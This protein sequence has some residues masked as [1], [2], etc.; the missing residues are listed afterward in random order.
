MLDLLASN[1]AS[2]LVFTSKKRGVLV[3]DSAA[4]HYHRTTWL[5]VLPSVPCF[6]FCMFHIFQIGQRRGVL[7][8]SMFFRKESSYSWMDGLGMV[9]VYWEPTKDVGEHSVWV[10]FQPGQGLNV[11]LKKTMHK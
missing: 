5:Y 2:D 6:A 3:D 7:R 9:K 8:V 1:V 11:N 4:K 10:F